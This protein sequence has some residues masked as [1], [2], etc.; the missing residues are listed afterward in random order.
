LPIAKIQVHQSYISKER[1][2][3]A[4]KPLETVW[5]N[6]KQGVLVSAYVT[7]KAQILAK[8]MIHESNLGFVKHCWQKP[9]KA[10]ICVL[11]RGF[12]NWSW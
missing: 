4:E 1:K 9:E 2:F 7:R 10:T 6:R 12:T 3:I 8:S 11:F 5:K